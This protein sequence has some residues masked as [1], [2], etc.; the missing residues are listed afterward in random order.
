MALD[1]EET[2]KGEDGFF[3]RSD[4]RET[5]GISGTPIIGDFTS[6]QHDHASAAGGGTVDHLNVTSI[7]TNSH[8]QIDT[9]VDGDGSDHSDVVANTSA[10]HAQ[11]H[12]QA[13]H[14]DDYTPGEGIN[15]S[16]GNEI[17]GENATVTNKGIA[18]FDNA[19][20]Q[21]TSGV[22]T[23]DADVAKT[24]D[25]DS[26]TATTAIHNID[27][28]G[29]VGITTLG[30]NNDITITNTGV[31]S[32]VAGLGIDVSRATGTVSISAEISTAGNLGAVIVSVSMATTYMQRR[33]P[34][35]MCGL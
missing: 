16:A 9:H 12:N 30:A 6:A 8:S 34:S 13:S 33:T 4:V 11:S 18:A 5:A 2:K 17:S 15:I 21:V 22:V 19:D 14:T 31:T 20:F 29:G 26:G 27:I 10:S 35:A 24:F 32:A 28:L 23:L 3:L 25:G 7:G 1:L